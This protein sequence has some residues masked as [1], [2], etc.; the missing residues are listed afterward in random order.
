VLGGNFL[1]RFLPESWFTHFLVPSNDLRRRLMKRYYGDSGIFIRRDT[2]FALGG[3]RPIPLME[4]YDLSRQLENAGR[5]VYIR[6]PSIYASARRF[7]SREL[8]TLF[9]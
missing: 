9:L 7:K 6:E 4:D 1:L 3:F 5:C 2:Y 8:R